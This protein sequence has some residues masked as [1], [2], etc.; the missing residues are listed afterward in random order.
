MNFSPGSGVFKRR[1]S[2][3]IT[4]HIFTIIILI[5]FTRPPTQIQHT[6]HIIMFHKV[7]F[8]LLRP[9]IPARPPSVA[10]P[11][12]RR[13]CPLR[14]SRSSLLPVRPVP[15]LTL[16]PPVGAPPAGVFPGQSSAASAF[17]LPVLS[18]APSC[19]SLRPGPCGALSGW[20]GR[21]CGRVRLLQF[22]QR[23]ER[24]TFVRKTS[25]SLSFLFKKRNRPSTNGRWN[26]PRPPPQK[27][28]TPPPFGKK[29][30]RPPPQGEYREEKRGKKGRRNLQTRAR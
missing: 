16:S 4:A 1:G 23:P 6:T 3:S 28:R 11:K 14:P 5:L 2:K 30:P 19:R 7:F 13:S 21:C 29:G 15:V 17:G 26:L 20:P 18:V 12:G 10:A 22:R 24:K 25:Q 27:T 9:G 8:A